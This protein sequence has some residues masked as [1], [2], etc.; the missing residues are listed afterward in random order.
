[1]TFQFS[2]NIVLPKPFRCVAEEQKSDALGLKTLIVRLFGTLFGPNVVGQLIE[3]A[4]LVQK[5]SCG[6][7]SSCWVYDPWVLLLALYGFMMVCK[8]ITLFCVAVAHQTYTPPVTKYASDKTNTSLQ[9][10]PIS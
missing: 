3:M 1:M 7:K 8:S 10:T 4:C 9:D 2:S 6:S 5:E